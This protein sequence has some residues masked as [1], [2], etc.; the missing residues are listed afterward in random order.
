LVAEVEDDIIAAGAEI[1]WVLEQDPTFKPGTAERCM[2]VMD[3]LG[4]GEVGWCVGDSETEPEAGAF[5]ESPFSIA[6]GFDMVVPRETMV[7]EYVTNHGTPS[8]ND[9]VDGEEVLQA[10]IDVVNGL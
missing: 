3:E 10:V 4:S 1:I 2:A 9:N 6:R 8:G 5:D 7:V